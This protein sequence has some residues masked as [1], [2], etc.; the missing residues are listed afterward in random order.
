VADGGPFYYSFA[1]Q[2]AG[3]N[4]VLNAVQLYSS[5]SFAGLPPVTMVQQNFNTKHFNM[6]PPASVFNVPDVCTNAPSCHFFGQVGVELERRYA[7][8]FF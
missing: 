5:F 8:R 6:R 7:A 2:Q 4:T 3:K 1:Q